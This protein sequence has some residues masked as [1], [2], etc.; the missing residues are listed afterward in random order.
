MVWIK[1]NRLCIVTNCKLRASFNYS[2]EKIFLYCS[3]HKKNNMVNLNG[4]KCKFEGCFTYPAF[5]YE[6]ENHG[7]FCFEHKKGKMINVNE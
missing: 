2:T 4:R 1:H 5:N 3:Q 7:I 6:K